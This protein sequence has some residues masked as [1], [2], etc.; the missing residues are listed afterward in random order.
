MSVDRIDYSTE[1]YDI[2]KLDTGDY[3]GDF[4]SNDTSGMFVVA[5]VEMLNDEQYGT[6]M[7]EYKRYEPSE[8]FNSETNVTSIVPV[9]AGY[10]SLGYSFYEVDS[11]MY[12]TQTQEF[13]LNDYWE[14]YDLTDLNSIDTINSDKRISEFNEQLLPDYGIAIEMSGVLDPLYRVVDN[15]QN[16]FLNAEVDYGSNGEGIPWIA[17][18]NIDPLNVEEEDYDPWMKLANA[19]DADETSIDPVGIYR[20]VLEGMW[21]PYDLVRTGGGASQYGA[22]YVQGGT[23]NKI[24]NLGN[25][26]IVITDD[27]SKWSQCMVLNYDLEGLDNFT[28]LNKSKVGTGIGT[29]PGYAINLD[30]GTRVEMFFAESAVSDTVNGDDLV[31]EPTN[32]VHGG[33]SYLYVTSTEYDAGVSYAAKFDSIIALSSPISTKAGLYVQHIFNDITWVGNIKVSESAGFMESSP[34]R[35]KLRVNKNY[36]STGTRKSPEYE[37]STDGVLA[38]SGDLNTADSALAL[39]RV[40]PNPYYAYSEYESSQLDNIVKLTNLPV[41]CNIR[42]YNASGTLVKVFNKSND[43]TYLDWNLQNQNGIPIASGAYFIHIEAEGIGEVVVKWFGVLR[44]F[45]LD[46]F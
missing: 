15:V 6:F 11:S 38:T 21:C 2:S 34:T 16:G 24:Y 37:F 31:W 23:D 35:I 12:S 36:R 46:T 13:N 32:K 43:A 28:T 14:L 5:K 39:I 3:K 30:N 7:Y 1:T 9:F 10:R 44:P 22:K 40:V 25:I 20:Q 45:D 27:E 33:R 4:I 42:I 17:A 41:T 26:D 29:F 19:D 18:P 8:S